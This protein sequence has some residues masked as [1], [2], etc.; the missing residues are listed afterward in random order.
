MVT[1]S[2]AG[3]RIQES[4][5]FRARVE[6][7]PRL[8]LLL[9]AFSE[10]NIVR[11]FVLLVSM[12]PIVG[13]FSR[14][15]VPLL[16]VVLLF[17]YL[18]KY[19]SHL[20]LKEA[21]I[22]LFVAFSIA[23]SCVFYPDNA[24]YILDSNNFWNTIFPCFK[25]FLLG[26]I[27]IPDKKT[28]DALGVLSLLAIVVESAFVLFYMIPNGLVNMDD[29][30]RSYQI[31]PNL[32]LAF[33]YTIN[34]KRPFSILCSLIGLAYCLSMGTRGP[35]MIVLAYIFVKTIQSTS[36]R[37]RNK[38]LL[39]ATM[40]IVGFLFLNSDFFVVF[41]EFI[42]T[43]ITSLGLS[44]RVVDLAIEGNVI[45][46]LSERDEIY[47]LLW[48]KIAQRPFWGYG[49]YGEWPWIQWNAHNMYL[50]LFV[51]F[52]VPLGSMIVLWILWQTGRCYFSTPSKSTKDMILIWFCFVF[53]KSIF[54]GSWL[55][56]GVFFLIGLCLRER[57]RVHSSYYYDPE[58]T[59]VPVDVFEGGAD[60]ETGDS[61]GR[62]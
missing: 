37:I 43:Q 19:G 53:V 24:S 11:Y 32:L 21:S 25:F 30:G 8:L 22:L 5:R 52:G 29:M 4:D 14:F 62:I 26:L 51:H 28:M 44:T 34:H 6:I 60:V 27:I 57:R 56:Y 48:E 31:L 12:I 49:V 15:I 54:G 17:L 16:Y 38:V 20:S 42:R 55:N 47:A 40:L 61:S 35:I 33:N 58:Q 13:D 50:E 1:D 3:I 2:N 18:K 59:V 9:L 7:N 39:G 41:L 10:K 46:H 23:F 36:L 45:S